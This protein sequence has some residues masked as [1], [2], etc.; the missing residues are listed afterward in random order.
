LANNRPQ[1]PRLGLRPFA[2]ALVILIGALCSCRQGAAP[3]EA[4]AAFSLRDDMGDSVAFTGTPRRVVSLAPSITETLYALGSDTLLTGVTSFCDYPP[5]AKTKPRVGDMVT[6]NIELILAQKPDLV[7]MAIEGNTRQSYDHLRSLGCRIFVTNP[8]TL[9]GI[10]KSLR[11]LG[12]VTG[13]QRRAA[14]LADSLIALLAAVPS[15]QERPKVLMALSLDPLIVAGAN[16]VLNDII[17][18]AGARNCGAAAAG[19][20]PTLN[21]EAVLDMDPDVLL[22]PSDLHASRERLLAAFPEWSRLAALRNGR[23]HIVNADVFLRPGPRAFF[24]LAELRAL[25]RNDFRQ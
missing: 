12:L 2:S 4:A 19:A 22:L 9:G 21:R 18:H 10:L 17:I 8:R 14:Q 24:G 11:D 25:L 20:Y 7:L 1:F 16:T 6:P 15:F 5:Q 13:A 23:I 3:R